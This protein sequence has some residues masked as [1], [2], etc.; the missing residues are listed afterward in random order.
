MWFPVSGRCYTE[1]VR[2]IISTPGF[3]RPIF[4]FDHMKFPGTQNLANLVNFWRTVVDDRDTMASLVQKKTDSNSQS[5]GWNTRREFASEQAAPQGGLR[6]R[7][8]CE[9]ANSQRGVFLL[10]IIEVAKE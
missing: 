4:G 9:R 1:G 5:G 3:T 6:P 7:A 10:E 2:P 8:A